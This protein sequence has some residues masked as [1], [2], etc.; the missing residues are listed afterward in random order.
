MIFQNHLQYLRNELSPPNERDGNSGFR[1]DRPL[2]Q[3]HLPA[4]DRQ[5]LELHSVRL[6]NSNPPCFAVLLSDS[7]HAPRGIERE[8]VTHSP[9]LPVVCL[10]GEGANI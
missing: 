3:A 6:Q 4:R 10:L 5:E 1:G 2:T 9:G 8:G 7:E